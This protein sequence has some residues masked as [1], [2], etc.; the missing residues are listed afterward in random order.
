[1]PAKKDN[2]DNAQS[3]PDDFKELRRQSNEEDFALS[4]ED[5]AALDALDETGGTEGAVEDRW[6]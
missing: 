6:W 5:I 2:T 3:S 1:M 4:D